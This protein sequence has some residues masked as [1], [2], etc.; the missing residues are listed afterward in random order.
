MRGKLG[1]LKEDIEDESI[2]I[3]L[4]KLM[5]KNNLDFTFIFSSLTMGDFKGHSFFGTDEFEGWKERWEKR[6]NI[7]EGGR[8]GGIKMMAAKNPWIIPRNSEVEAAIE[9]AVDNENYTPLGQL[10]D[11]LS[12]PF[13]YSKIVEEKRL[14]LEKSES[15]YKTYCGT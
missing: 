2:I 15:Q 12:T 13:D 3:D 14:P 6:L 7:Q 8:I 4:L 10:L 9:A 5:E 1:L 11:R